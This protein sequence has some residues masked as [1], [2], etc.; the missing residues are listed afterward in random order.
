MRPIPSLEKIGARVYWRGGTPGAETDWNTASNWNTKRVPDY[1]NAVIIPDVTEASG[2]SPVIDD[3]VPPVGH[4]NILKGG[5]MAIEKSGVLFIDG[6]CMFHNGMTN[7]GK[8]FNYGDLTIMNV[9][10]TCV[11]NN[12]SLF[13]NC[14]HITLDTIIEEAFDSD[15]STIFVNISEI[16]TDESLVFLKL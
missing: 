6:F 16:H 15:F 10:I 13:V 4:I 8:L 9:G 11:Q 5:R 2:Y 1:C 3:I 7:S 12:E 14:G